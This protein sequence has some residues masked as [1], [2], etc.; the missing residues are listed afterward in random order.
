MFTG[1]LS[2][3]LSDCPEVQKLVSQLEYNRKS[4]LRAF[5][6]YYECVSDNRDY[7]KKDRKINYSTVAVAGV[8]HT[9]F[10]GEHLAASTD[11]VI[12]ISLD[13]E[14]PWN[15][16][17]WTWSN[18]FLLTH[19]STE[20]AKSET[21]R[22]G[23][24]T[25]YDYEKQAVSLKLH[26]M[27]RYASRGDGLRYFLGAGLLCGYRHSLNGRTIKYTKFGPDSET[28]TWEDPMGSMFP[29]GYV[30]GAGGSLKKLSLQL[31]Y[32]NIISSNSMY[33]LLG[34]RIGS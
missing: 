15:A 7:A 31:C 9:S 21:T 27:L 14:F 5:E 8:S 3:Y 24:Y 20:G 10:G 34:Y 2:N 18:T 23:R 29:F 17:R 28:E 12:G 22:L 11:P 16:R 30:L 32:E 4:L 25:R 1:Q 33:L 19:F 26:S 13:A 6:N